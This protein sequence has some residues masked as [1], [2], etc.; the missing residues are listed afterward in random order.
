[1]IKE[2]TVQRARS[3]MLTMALNGE[4][5]SH[6]HMQKLLTAVSLVLHQTSTYLH[7]RMVSEHRPDPTVVWSEHCFGEKK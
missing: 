6:R 7:D 5:C 1:V 3:E 4:L 2:L